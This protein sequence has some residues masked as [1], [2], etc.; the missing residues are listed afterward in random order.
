MTTLLL[1][2]YF[3]YG[4]WHSTRKCSTFFPDIFRQ[5]NGNFCFYF[6]RLLNVKFLCGEFTGNSLQFIFCNS[7]RHSITLPETAEH[8]PKM[9]LAACCTFR[10][11]ISP[12]IYT[13]GFECALL[14]EL[15]KL[16][17]GNTE[18]CR[19]YWDCCLKD[20]ETLLFPQIGVTCDV[21]L[22]SPCI[23]KFTYEWGVA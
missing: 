6:L 14:E 5:I 12:L 23:I 17:N 21:H 13:L 7:I 10:H 11:M 22:E 16:E 1:E 19:V 2:R 4:C 18:V 9:F 3:Q 15:T 20:S 8:F